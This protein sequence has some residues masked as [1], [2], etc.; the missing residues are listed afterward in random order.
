MDEEYP[1][2]IAKL[3]GCYALKT[4]LPATIADAETIHARYKD[5]A[6]VERAFRTMK[7][8]LL[9]VRPVFVR[10]ADHTRAHVLVV[11]PAYLIVRDLEKAWSNLNRFFYWAKLILLLTFTECIKFGKSKRR[12]VVCF[13]VKGKINIFEEDTGSIRKSRLNPDPPLTQ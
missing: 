5:L 1:A 3:D 4:D 13:F 8:G 7:T 11:M 9:E 2:E 6:M 10:R 12:L